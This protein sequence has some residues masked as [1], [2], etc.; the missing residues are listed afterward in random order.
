MKKTFK[1]FMKEQT[2]PNIVGSAG[3]SPNN[4]VGT[5]GMGPDGFPN[6]LSVDNLKRKRLINFTN[7]RRSVTT[8]KFN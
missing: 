5:Q 6:K 2:V 8:N 4:M 3:Q 7:F 1:Q